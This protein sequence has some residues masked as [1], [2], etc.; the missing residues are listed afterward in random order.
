MTAYRSRML[1]LLVA[2]TIAQAS[3]E[4]TEATEIGRL[5]F[6][7]QERETLDRS[8]DWGLPNAG[9]AADI[10]LQV[11]GRIRRSTGRNTVWVNGVPRDEAPGDAAAGLRAGE[12]WQ[13][14]TRTKHDLIGD[15]RIA[16][17]RQR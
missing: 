15:G 6:T 10:R 14:A 4:T 8:R 11:D 2:A 3:A 13:P 1:R 12:S 9:A 16:V 17:H 7:P 5:F